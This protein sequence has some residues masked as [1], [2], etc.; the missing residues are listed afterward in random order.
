MEHLLSFSGNQAPEAAIG[1][2]QERKSFINK[3]YLKYMYRYMRTVFT[4]T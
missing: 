2:A 3:V 4:S 1:N